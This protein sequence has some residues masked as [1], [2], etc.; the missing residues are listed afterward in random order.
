MS[1]R[2]LILSANPKGTSALDLNIEIREIRQVLKGSDYIL[3]TRGAVRPADLQQALLEVQPQIVHFCG[4]GE[5][6]EGLVLVGDRGKIKFASTKALANLFKIFQDSIECIVLN[7]CYTK[8]QATAI[9]NHIN[10]VVG[11]NRSILDES[12][13]IFARGFYGGISAEKAIATA[14]EL[15]KNAI[16]LEY[17]DQETIRRKLVPI[18]DSRK[19]EL[20]TPEHLIPV[21]IQKANPISITPPKPEAEPNFSKDAFQSFIGHSDS[22]RAIAFTPDGKYLASASDDRTVRLWDIATGQ[23]INLFKGHKERV[24]CVQISADGKQIVSGSADSTL[25]IW[26]LETGNC[27]K[28]I[29][30]SLNPKTVLN[31]IAINSKQ[32]FIATGSTSVKGTIKLWHWQTGE[33]LDA[34]STAFSGIRSLALSSDARILVSGSGGKTIKIWDLEKGLQEPQIIPNAHMSDVF[35]LTICDRAEGEVLRDRILISGG[36]DRTIKRWN[37]DTGKE[38]RSA[39]ILKGHA[40]SIR[41]LAISPDGK[42]LASAS[43]DHTVKIWEIETGKFRE[44]LTG[45]FEVVRAV[46]FSPDGKILASA[47]DDWDIKLWQVE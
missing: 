46:A 32:R 19:E 43:S 21:L 4:H 40:G 23:L 3:E 25:K 44:T 9:S 6:T 42:K 38:M 45:H 34:V 36:K 28:T 39:H 26:D 2:I 22:V 33:M 7:A 24:K 47:G 12:A 5:G 30:T 16:E 1:K 8:V 37:L 10:Y 20:P 17:P 35:S 41:D 11:M 14:Y 27:T 31:A 15:G 29:K 13:I 18:L